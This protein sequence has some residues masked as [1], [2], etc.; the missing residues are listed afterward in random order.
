MITESQQNE[1]QKIVIV[2][3]NN[4]MRKLWK[5]LV[6]EKYFCKKKSVQSAFIKVRYLIMPCPTD[7]SSHQISANPWQIKV[8]RVTLHVVEQ[9]SAEFIWN[10]TFKSKLVKLS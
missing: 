8:N 1:L 6:P 7:I 10:V 5:K 3:L 2:H 9:K 4:V